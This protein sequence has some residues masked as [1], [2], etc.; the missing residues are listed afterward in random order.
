MSS[1]FS[2][3]TSS[4]TVRVLIPPRRPWPFAGLVFFL[5]AARPGGVLACEEAMPYRALRMSPS[6]SFCRAMIQG[7]LVMVKRVC[8]RSSVSPTTSMGVL[9]AARSSDVFG[10]GAGDVGAG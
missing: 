2:T 6:P 7:T 4:S 1:T 5:A 8:C 10:D 3:L 9:L